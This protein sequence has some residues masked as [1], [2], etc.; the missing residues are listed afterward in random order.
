MGRGSAIW[1]AACAR[2][3]DLPPHS[4]EQKSERTG[5]D[6]AQLRAGVGAG[7]GSLRLEAEG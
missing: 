4:R 7:A 3:A 5:G 2:L 1:A 6:A